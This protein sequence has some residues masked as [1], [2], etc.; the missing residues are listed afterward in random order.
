MSQGWNKTLP[1]RGTGLTAMRC[2]SG[3]VRS[4]VSSNRMRRGV[5]IAIAVLAVVTLLRPLDCFGAVF[6]KKAA[7]CCHK[8]KCLPTKDADE[9]CKA[10]VPSGNQ[11]TVP[12][13]PDHST[14]LPVVLVSEVPIALV[15][16]SFTVV[17]GQ[18]D[19]PPGSPPGSRLNLPL[20][21]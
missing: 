17:L 1:D 15:A 4:L 10:T 13:S 7:E 12:K 8:G 6:S 14:Q 20:L 21:I 16:T 9:C 18:A 11:L 3:A 2:L 5:Q 19:A